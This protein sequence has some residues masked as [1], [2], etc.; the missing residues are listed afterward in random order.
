VAAQMV[1]AVARARRVY[2]GGNFIAAR[3]RSLGRN[4]S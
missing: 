4:R 2:D 1:A 3:L